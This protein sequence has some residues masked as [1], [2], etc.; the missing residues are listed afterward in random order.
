MQRE[1]EIACVNAESEVLNS[2]IVNWQCPRPIIAWNFKRKLIVSTS[3]STFDG[4]EG[5]LA[6]RIGGYQTKQFAIFRK[7]GLVMS[8]RLDYSKPTISQKYIRYQLRV[9]RSLFGSVE[10]MN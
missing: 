2:Y 4:M 10:Q 8:E 1:I 5:S 7:I 3:H 9:K 6:S